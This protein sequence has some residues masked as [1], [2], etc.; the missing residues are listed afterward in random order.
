[1]KTTKHLYTT[2]YKILIANKS[3]EKKT[4]HQIK[5]LFAIHQQ[6][7]HNATLEK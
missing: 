6:Q 1:M 4:R 2:Y 3:A 7:P 5:K